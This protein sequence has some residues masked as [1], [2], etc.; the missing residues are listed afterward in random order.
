MWAVSFE[1]PVQA[2][3]EHMRQAA[4]SWVRTQYLVSVYFCEYTVNSH[5]H[6]FFIWPVVGSDNDS[7][8]RGRLTEIVFTAANEERARGQQPPALL[9]RRDGGR[10]RTWAVGNISECS[11]TQLA[12]L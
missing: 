11:D 6:T 8:P 5:Q 2:G 3:F 1:W 4:L 7:L 12:R 9:T 10:Q